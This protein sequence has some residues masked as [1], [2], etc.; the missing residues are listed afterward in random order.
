MIKL[1]NLLLEIVD[2]ESLPYRLRYP[3]KN[4]L[5][6]LNIVKVLNRIEHDDPN[7]AITNRQSKNI[8]SQSRID[9]AKEF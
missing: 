1:L 3:A 7:Y 2:V 5:I 4:T 9:S 6:K 8:I